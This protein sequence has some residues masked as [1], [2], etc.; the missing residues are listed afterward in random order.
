MSANSGRGS[1]TLLFNPFYY[2]AGAKALALGLAA[3]L[4][5]GFVGALS[6]THFD[7]VLDTHVGGRAP[8]WFFLSEGIIDW[9]CMAA[10]LLVA[11]AIIS[12][13]TFR[14]I[15]VL[16]TQ[17]LARWPSPLLGLISVSP[18]FHRFA[19]YLIQHLSKAE[20]ETSFQF[21]DA[22]MFFAVLIATALL[23]AWVVVL[24]YQAFSVACNVRGGKAIG[25][26]IG[27]L[28][29]AEVISKVALYWL[30]FCAA[31]GA[32]SPM[33]EASV[34]SLE[35]DGVQI[36]EFMARGEFAAVTTRFDGT[37]KR[38]L[39]EAKLREVWQQLQ[40]Q[41]GPFKARLQSRIT[42]QRGYDVVFVTC[43]FERADLDAKVVFNP[44]R[45]IAGLFFVPIR[46]AAP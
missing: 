9:L 25:A 34:G 24:M 36:V 44:D 32:R 19:S 6:L 13:T 5:A 38:V 12:K 41:V 31:P 33:A 37:M 30:F 22:A 45:Q 4:L 11:G 21:T 14:V 43:Q 8:L 1:A 18:G 42:K 2:L 20:T 15:D 10:L 29:L 23:T 46:A 17:A 7:G 40:E 35:G 28:F 39:P 26:F 27:A 3:I 16:G